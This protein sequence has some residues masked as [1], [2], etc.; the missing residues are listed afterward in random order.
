MKKILFPTDFS[1]T[2][3]NA[4]IYALQLAKN[5]NAEVVTLHVY[6]LPAVDYINVPAYLLE[7]YDSVEMSNFQ[8]YKDQIPVL[9]SIAEQNGLADIKISNVMMDGDLVNTILHMVKE[10]HID[11]IVM[12]TKGA[13]GLKETFLGSSTSRV[14]AESRAVVLCIPEESTYKNIERI[15]FTTRFRDKDQKALRKVLDLAK[16]FNAHVDCLHIQKSGSDVKEVVLADWNL[17]F[18]H[19]DMTIHILKSDD[20]EQAII[21]FTETNHTD[22]LAMLH[23]KHGFFENLFRRSLTEKLALHIKIPLLALHEE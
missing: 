19:D 14:I 6:E 20:V 18:A 2:S 16:G 10:D 15:T 12:G 7:I 5:I 13:T 8:N 3:N 21:H 23:Y 1:S 4:F 11:Y 9:R 22:L 17:L